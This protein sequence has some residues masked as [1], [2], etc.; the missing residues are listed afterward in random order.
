MK[1][2]RALFSFLLALSSLITYAQ[3]GHLS[4][5]GVPIDGTLN[6]YVQEM[7]QKGFTLVK[8]GKGEAILRGDFAGIKGC[9][10]GVYTLDAMDLVSNIGV[11]FPNQIT[12]A[13]LESDYQVLKSNLTDKYG[14]PKECVEKFDDRYVDDDNDRMHALKFDK[15]HYYTIWS[16]ELGDIELSLQRDEL[17]HCYVF[18]KYY[19]RINSNAV[20]NVIM[21]DL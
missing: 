6:H 9:E 18:L 5:K 4:F 20:Q 13:R 12:W 11:I 19:D 17:L 10:I 3:D 2:I 8:T 14:R 15:C 1:N 16:T 7:R 21:E